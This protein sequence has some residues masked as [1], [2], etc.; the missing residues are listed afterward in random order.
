MDR[1]SIEEENSSHSSNENNMDQRMRRDEEY[2]MNNSRITL[3]THEGFNGF[4][5]EERKS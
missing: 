3:F 1:D 5:E 4:D 2:V